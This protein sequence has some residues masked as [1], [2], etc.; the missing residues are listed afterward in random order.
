MVDL[1]LVDEK[2]LMKNIMV[3]LSNQKDFWRRHL[4]TI[5]ARH[6]TIDLEGIRYSFCQQ[7]YC[8]GPRS[9]EVLCE[10]IDKQL[11]PILQGVPKKTQIVLPSCTFSWKLQRST[12][13]AN[14]IVT[15]D[16]S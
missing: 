13:T 6:N 12:P 15:R 3:M 7:I 4:R 11:E 5:K 1:S 8:V 2:A 14:E 9:L 10:K 16:D